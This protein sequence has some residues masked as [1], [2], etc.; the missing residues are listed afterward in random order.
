MRLL[1]T[2]RSRLLPFHLPGNER[3]VSPVSVF[4]LALPLTRRWTR[5]QTID[6]NTSACSNALIH[7]R[8]YI[9]IYNSPPFATVMRRVSGGATRNVNCFIH[10]HVLTS[11]FLSPS[12]PIFGL[13]AFALKS[14]ACRRARGEHSFVSE[15]FICPSIM[16]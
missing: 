6:A 7:N 5:S 10:F 12:W 15:S 4:F 16:M 9:Y 13:C 11:P 3:G 8:T 1:N 2:H 14:A